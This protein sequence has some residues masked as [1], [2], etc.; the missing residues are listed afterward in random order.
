MI[1]SLLHAILTGVLTG[2]AIY[3]FIARPLLN[4]KEEVKAERDKYKQLLEFGTEGI[5]DKVEQQE[6]IE[7]LHQELIQ[8]RDAHQKLQNEYNQYKEKKS[9]VRES[10]RRN[11]LN[12][13]KYPS[14]FFRED[15]GKYLPPAVHGDMRNHISDEFHNQIKVQK[16]LQEIERLKKENERLKD[17]NKNWD[18]LLNGTGIIIEKGHSNINKKI[19]LECQDG[20]V[21]YLYVRSDE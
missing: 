4:E 11:I 3:F 13:L 15:I 9:S 6:L 18:V 21:E 16:I 17:K 10:I 7:E 20:P 2:L 1:E 8:L 14:S 5:M 19:K 12:P